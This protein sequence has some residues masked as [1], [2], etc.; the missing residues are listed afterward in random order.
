MFS[1]STFDLLT[2]EVVIEAVEALFSLRLDGTITP[3]ASY[4]NRVFGIRDDDGYEYVVKFYRPGRWSGEALLEEHRFLDALGAADIPVVPPISDIDGDTLFEALVDGAEGEVTYP[5]SLFPKR[6]GR[7][8]DAEGDEDWLR[9][10]ALIGRVHA[11]GEVE[12]AMHR[13]TVS[14]DE[15]TAPFVEELLNEEVVHPDFRG[16]FRDV[17]E[18]GLQCLRGRFAEPGRIRLHGDCHRGNILER[19]DEGL[20]L[21]DFDDMMMGPAVQDLW[22]LLPDHADQCRRE[23]NLLLEGYERFRPFDRQELELIEGLRFM[24][25]IHFLAWRARQRHDHWFARE[26]PDWGN[27]AFWITEIEDLREQRTHFS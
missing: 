6:G 22:L 18:E 15:W 14:P 3:Y 27:R 26:F 17:A 24:R 13:F 16:E 23:I 19:G 8:F 11:V 12:E 20:L 1:V 7:S 10:G 4:V 5:F 25:M 9:L 21:I 2:P